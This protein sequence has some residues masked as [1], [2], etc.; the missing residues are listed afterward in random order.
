M[1]VSGS[2]C[3]VSCCEDWFAENVE[4]DL[5]FV[6]HFYVRC[7]LVVGPLHV[8]VPHGPVSFPRPEI[9]DAR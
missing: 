4:V 5:R 8:L 9:A 2:R 6:S 3:S 1:G 7:R